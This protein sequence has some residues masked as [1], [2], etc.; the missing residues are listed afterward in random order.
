MKHLYSCIAISLVIFFGINIQLSGQEIYKPDFITR[1][2]SQENNS[3][4]KYYFLIGW[5]YTATR[6]S[7]GNRDFERPFYSGILTQGN[8]FQ[9]GFHFSRKWS[10]ISGI[11]LNVIA[12]NSIPYER[13]VNADVNRHNVYIHQI[14]Y[15]ILIMFE[16]FDNNKAFYQQLVTG[17]YLG[18]VLNSYYI[19]Q[20]FDSG[21][22]WQESGS[23]TNGDP[24]TH[25]YNLYGGTKLN[26]RISNK[27][28]LGMEPFISYQLENDQIIINVYNRFLFGFKVN[29]M[30]NLINE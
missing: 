6:Y 12:I 21:K 26:Y 7:T 27:F 4:R 20:L 24:K 23:Y 3:G 8:E 30:F 5:A 25:F 17:I 2:K 9:V 29:L 16:V 28:H 13:G 1:E 19:N 11:N 10:L 15:P 14:S 18:T 22:G